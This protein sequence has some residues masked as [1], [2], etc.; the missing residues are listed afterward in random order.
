MHIVCIRLVKLISLRVKKSR[1]GF[2]DYTLPE[3]N[4]FKLKKD[5]Y[6]E[7]E[8]KEVE[9]FKKAIKISNALLHAF[10]SHDMI[11]YL[12]VFTV[13]NYRPLQLFHH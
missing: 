4:T 11:L 2:K 13:Y 3:I 9:I 12:R 6:R 10:C 1:S 8:M 5:D 7:R